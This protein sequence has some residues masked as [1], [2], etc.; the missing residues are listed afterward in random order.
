MELM[1]TIHITFFLVWEHENKV[2]LSTYHQFLKY[3]EDGFEKRIIVYDNPL[4]EAEAQFASA[5]FY[6]KKYYA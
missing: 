6:L 2:I 3:Y 1:Q 5:K 4:T